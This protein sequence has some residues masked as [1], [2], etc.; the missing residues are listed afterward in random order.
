QLARVTAPVV[1]CPRR[2]ENGQLPCTARSPGS[3]GRRSRL[4]TG[5]HEHL[6][7]LVGLVSLVG[8]GLNLVQDRRNGTTRP[9]SGSAV[10]L[11]LP[12][13]EGRRCARRG[14]PVLSRVFAR[15]ASRSAGSA[16]CACG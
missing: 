13:Q 11:W 7:G 9:A 10:H 1:C 12:R 15:S 2:G 14:S 8:G 5:H 16:K 6:V 3:T 4:R